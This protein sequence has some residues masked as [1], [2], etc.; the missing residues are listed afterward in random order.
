M[1]VIAGKFRSRRLKG[2]GKLRLRPTS[3]RLRET[4]FNILGPAIED[5]LFVDLYAGTGAIGIEAISRGAR[6]T[7]FVEAHAA[8]ARLVRENLAAL[9]AGASA[10]VIEASAI[11]GLEKIAARHRIADFIFLDPPYE[12]EDE[13]LIVLEFLDASHL[14]A[15]GGRVIVEHR[16]KNTLPERFD[17]LE[18]IRVVEQGD[19]ALSFYRLAAAA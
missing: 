16:K 11:P 8:T 13:Y 17:R 1:R 18:R 15:P 3:D 19:A 2:P 6:E 4:L 7:I 9:G 10:E 5:S 12:S 14:L